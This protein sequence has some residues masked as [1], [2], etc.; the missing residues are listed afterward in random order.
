MG[1]STLRLRWR[2]RRLAQ[3]IGDQHRAAEVKALR[4]ELRDRGHRVPI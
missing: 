2:L 3:H 1:A 4:D